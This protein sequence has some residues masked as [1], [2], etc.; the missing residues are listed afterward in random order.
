MVFRVILGVARI[1][2]VVV[3]VRDWVIAM[4][5]FFFKFNAIIDGS[6]ERGNVA[7][8][9]V[10]VYMLFSNILYVCAALLGYFD[11]RRAT[12]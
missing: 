4:G 6:G 5:Q 3:V 2:I 11:L 10:A 1:V 7:T 8:F 9:D 12:N